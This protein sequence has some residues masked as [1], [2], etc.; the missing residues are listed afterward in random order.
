M[1][2]ENEIGMEP[3]PKLHNNISFGDHNAF[4]SPDAAGGSTQYGT[5]PHFRRAEL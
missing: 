4:F 5:D 2:L 1:E 3:F